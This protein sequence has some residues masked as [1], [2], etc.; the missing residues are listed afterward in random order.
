MIS[1]EHSVSLYG[2]MNLIIV[3]VLIV[4]CIISSL[5]YLIQTR[6]YWYVHNEAIECFCC[7]NHSC[8]KV[9]SLGRLSPL[10]FGVSQSS[11]TNFTDWN[12]K[13]D[14]RGRKNTEMKLRGNPK[15]WGFSGW[16]LRKGETGGC[17]QNLNVF[18][19]LFCSFSRNWARLE[20]LENT[21]IILMVGQT[22]QTLYTHS[23]SQ[24][25]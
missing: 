23:F 7:Q 12:G 6:L 18:S 8:K 20:D 5:I 3:D 17:V 1:L 19:L 2:I 11:L 16:S 14:K 22:N 15:F 4:V 21:D 13:Y 10:G 24:C 25:V 9:T